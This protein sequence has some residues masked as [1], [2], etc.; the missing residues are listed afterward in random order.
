MQAPKSQ[1]K[2]NESIALVRDL[3]DKQRLVEAMVHSHSTPKHD[4]VESL[5]HRQHLTELRTKVG[6][7][8]TADI[9]HILEVLPLDDRLL[10]WNQ[11]ENTR[12]GEILLEVSDAVRKQ[13]VTTMDEAELLA[14]LQQMDGDDLAY[15]AD[16][17]PASAL[18][19]RLQSLTRE[20]Q[21][22][23]RSAMEYEED[24]AGHLMSNEMVMVRD[25]DSLEQAAQH[26]RSLHE[27]PIHNDKL[28]VIDRRGIL[29][30]VLPLQSL[31]LNEPSTLISEIMAKEA[32]KFSPDDDASEVS[33][34]FERY[35][36]V[37][38]PVINPRGKLIGRLTVDVVMDYLRE[39]S[40][41]DVLGM[42]GLQGEEDLFSSIWSSARN[43][44]FWL[45][46]NLIT[47]F[48]VSRV[49]GLF[50]DS[51]AHLVALAALMP[52]V[53]NLGGNIGNQ[54][55]VIV[56]RGMSLGQITSQ[57]LPYL[58][59][60]ELGVS[61]LNGIALGLAVGLFTL[62][63]YHNLALAMVI[64]ASMLLT[65]VLAAL[66]GLA[67]PLLLD[68]SGRDPALGSSVILTSATDSLGFFIF[69]GLATVFLIH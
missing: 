38:A 40:T 32:V 5:V 10:I 46:I 41:E 19:T 1:E 50:E 62:L 68:K 3:L 8:H 57:I 64:S 48:I 30:G 49:I 52:I 13:L 28:F 16:D 55:A 67:V 11:V 17:I 54:T 18:Q 60:K 27:L 43:R 33:K 31:L 7:L 53:A 47:V 69:L 23:L 34:A 14:V 25:S 65:L 4:L 37:S 20:D 29:V 26:L 42:A 2:L 35:D 24:T 22:W 36:L 45:T 6:R 66:V 9:A 59:R 15:I 44:G 58:L 12:G 21:H 61:L 56:I 51:I 39:E 63:L